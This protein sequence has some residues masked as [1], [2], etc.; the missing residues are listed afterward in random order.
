MDSEHGFSAILAKT[1]SVAVVGNSIEARM[2]QKVVIYPKFS[3]K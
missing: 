3:G 1:K 2:P